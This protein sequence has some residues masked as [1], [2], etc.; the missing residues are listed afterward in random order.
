MS[1]VPNI[2]TL[3]R[4]FMVPIFVA[5]FIAF[6]DAPGIALC[7]YVLA[8]LTDVVDG[9]I[10]RAFNCTSR[11]GTLADPLAD[12]LM[13]LSV[14]ICLCWSRIIPIAAMVLV[15]I[16]EVTMISVGAFAAKHNIVIAACLP[17]KLATVLFTA[18]LVF[19]IPW[20]GIV[21]LESAAH[22]L[23][24]IAIAVAFYAAFYYTV[25]LK[26]RIVE[27]KQPQAGC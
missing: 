7:I 17:G 1:I 10:A 3:I 15:A 25:I 14:V 9:K 5:A 26:R 13:T 8:M 21:W 16:R 6:P 2:L 18:A 27:M 4:L 20:H 19:L 12:K 22:W 11:F 23:L 24:Y